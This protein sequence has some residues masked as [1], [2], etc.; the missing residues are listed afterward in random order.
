MSVE[1]VSFGKKYFQL[2]LSLREAMFLRRVLTNI[3]LW[4][5]LTN[6]EIEELECLDRIL[7]RQILGLSESTSI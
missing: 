3:E 6:T 1:T 2:A 5:G 7:L 4:Y